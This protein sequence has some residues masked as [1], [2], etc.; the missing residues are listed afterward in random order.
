[1]NA[2]QSLTK[3]MLELLEATFKSIQQLG[4]FS[5]LDYHGQLLTTIANPSSLNVISAKGWVDALR[6]MEFL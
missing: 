6:K 2:N 4:T 1:M 3:R 5:K